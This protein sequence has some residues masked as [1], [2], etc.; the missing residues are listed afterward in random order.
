[1]RVASARV[2]YIIIGI[3]WVIHHRLIRDANYIYYGRDKRHQEIRLTLK[4]P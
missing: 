3:D 2:L 1:M 4:V